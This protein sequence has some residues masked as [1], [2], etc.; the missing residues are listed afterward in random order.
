MNSIAYRLAGLMFL[1]VALTVILI[2]YLA[3]LQMTQLFQ[4]YLVIQNSVPGQGAGHPAGGHLGMP[5]MTFLESV[6][7]SL[8]WVGAV[9][10]VIGMAASY[11]M[12]RSITVP[13]RNLSR[14]AE[15]I[16]QG[17]LNQKV[18]VETK[19]EV[20]HLAAIFNRMVETLSNNNRMRR[21]FLAN[22]AHELRTPL[23][24]IQGHLEGMADGVI[25]PNREQLLSLHEESI[26]LNRLITDLRDLSLAEVGQLALDK[27]PAGLN[28]VV[29]K[30]TYLLQPM[31]DAKQI[32]MSVNFGED[33]PDVTIDVD[34]I[35]QVV[36][37]LLVN[38]VSY[39]HEGGRV[40]I[41]T[42][43]IVRGGT[44]WAAIVVQ[45]N[46]PGIS[47]EDLPHLFD[48][49]YRG[50]KS[51]NRKSGGSGLGLA[52]VRHLVEA[53]GGTVEAAGRQDRGARFEVRLPGTGCRK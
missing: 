32:Q 12:A 5:E 35:S 2:V 48:H 7:A 14:A 39:T 16:A 20:G 27:Q 18:P 44:V 33:V 26:R 8:I 19:D 47:A 22:I 29:R 36:C 24:I 17:N 51:R 49:F 38:A 9:M 40:D 30:A 23:A 4:E 41:C 53:H 15:A 25:E 21:Q 42:K 1:T 10:M 46:G 11:L 3:N 28:E 6:H 50:E 37:N 43:R 45:D 13:L 31:A 52:I 34:R